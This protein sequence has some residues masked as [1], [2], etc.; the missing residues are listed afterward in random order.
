[1]RGD[2]VGGEDGRGRIR[3]G[4]EEGELLV[5]RWGRWVRVWV[6]AWRRVLQRQW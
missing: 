4:D 2:R 5:E 1:L 6:V 3:S